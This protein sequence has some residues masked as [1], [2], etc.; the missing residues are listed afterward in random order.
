MCVLASSPI[1][2]NIIGICLNPENERHLLVWG[3]SEACVVII[4]PHWDG[5]ETKI[6]LVLDLDQ[7]D[8]ESDYLV[9]CG[10][11]P[12]SQT[13]LVVGCGHY[14]RVFDMAR[15]KDNRANAIVAYNLGFDVSLRD[16]ALV[17]LSP[18]ESLEGDSGPRN[19]PCVLSR[20]FMLLENGRLHT[21]DLKADSEGRMESPGDE[22]CELSGSVSLPTA[23]V[24]TRIGS[25]IGAAGSVAKSLGEGSRIVYLRQ[26]RILLYKC[27]S[28]CVVALMLDASGNVEGSFELIPHVLSSDVL[29][30]GSDGHNI[31]GPFHHW[32][33]LGVVYNEDGVYF[34]VACL[35]R[36]SRTNQA[37]L[38]CLE[39]NEKDVRIKEIGWNTTGS[40]NLHLAFEGLC[41]FSLPFV[42]DAVKEAANF[43]ERVFLCTATSSGSLLFYG[44]EVV[45]TVGKDHGRSDSRI[46]LVSLSDL[47]SLHAKQPTFP[48]TIF[49]SL[50]NVSEY[51]AVVFTSDGTGR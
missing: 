27:V 3:V 20:M 30:N 42:G 28:S 23:G 25:P 37:R 45:D 8:G 19:Q 46:S 47:S 49:E 43:G 16:I 34:R 4:K 29:W 35:G 31:V 24:R 44:E 41:A 32:T 48:L 51:E 39:F 50:K 5:V 17:P 9:M 33:E 22:P 14:V 2:F 26:S 12:G 6:D 40:V 10:F 36:S 1:P 38:V 21:V 7:P 11:I 15:S 18:W 13:S